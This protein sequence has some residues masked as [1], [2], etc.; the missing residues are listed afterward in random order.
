MVSFRLPADVLAAVER[1][2]K[3]EDRT[4]SSW[5]LRVL[6]DRLV[7]QG[8]LPPSETPRAAAKRTNREED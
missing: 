6:R 5:I 3:D 7:R 1:A 2:A 4:R 8:Y